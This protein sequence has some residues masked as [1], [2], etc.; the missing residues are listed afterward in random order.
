MSDLSKR[1]PKEAKFMDTSTFPFAEVNMESVKSHVWKH[2]LRDKKNSVAKCKIC[3]T[4]LK[5]GASTS[6]LANHL[7]RVH[8]IEEIEKTVAST[9]GYL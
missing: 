2:F 9:R 8:K 6:S 1:G 5:C 4:I 7:K 3:D